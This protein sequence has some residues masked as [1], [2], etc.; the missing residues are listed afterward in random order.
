MLLGST[1]TWRFLTLPSELQDHIM[2]YLLQA[3]HVHPK[4]DQQRNPRAE[5]DWIPNHRPPSPIFGRYP[6][7]DFGGSPEPHQQP[8][9]SE[10]ESTF[11]FSATPS[12]SS[13]SLQ[14]AKLAIHKP[15]YTSKLLNRDLALPFLAI[16]K[17]TSAI[18]IPF[19]YRENVF[20]IPPGP[21]SSTMSYFT[22]LPAD[23]RAMIR[24]LS[25]DCDLCDIEDAVMTKVETEVWRNVII[26]PTR[27]HVVGRAVATVLQSLWMEKIRAVS[28]L[29]L[30]GLESVMLTGYVEGTKVELSLDELE[31]IAQREDGEVVVPE[32]P[33]ERFIIA[34]TKTLRKTVIKMLREHNYPEACRMWLWYREHNSPFVREECS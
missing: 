7:L 8:D 27:S 21:A 17:A 13:V 20:Q 26:M 6:N 22:D 31:S 1:S 29:D 3:R 10:V 24:K 18:A 14:I 33:F 25:L 34:V 23:R 9:F 15:P 19:F 32:V 2:S 11:S 5:P 4:T 12:V 30:A 28:R 16:N